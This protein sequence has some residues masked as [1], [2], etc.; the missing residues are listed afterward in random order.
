MKKNNQIPRA[1]TVNQNQN[2]KISTFNIK[3]L[4]T[5]EKNLDIYYV[6]ESKIIYTSLEE[7]H[8]LQ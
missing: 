4:S 3:T 5:T 6:D 8:F 7:F 2:L 1:K